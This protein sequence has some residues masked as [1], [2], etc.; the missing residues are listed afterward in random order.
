MS[1]EPS[2]IESTKFCMSTLCALG[3]ES[4]GISTFQTSGFAKPLFEVL[5]NSVMSAS[6]RL[7]VSLLFSRTTLPRVPQI[8]KRLVPGASPVEDT[9][10]PVPPSAH[11]R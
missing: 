10:T 5:L 8:S 9:K 1:G 3:T 7:N 4:K 11:S 2:R 6:F